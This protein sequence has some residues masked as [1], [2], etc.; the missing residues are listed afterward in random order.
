MYSDCPVVQ[1]GSFCIWIF[2]L[3]HSRRVVV[4]C[5]ISKVRTHF[6]N[7]SPANRSTESWHVTQCKQQQLS[8]QA[9]KKGK[10]NLATSLFSGIMAATRTDAS[11]QSRVFLSVTF[12][13]DK[14]CII[15][16][17]FY[18]H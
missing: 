9:T 6:Y 15:C 10:I 4:T 2:F 7:I 11:I 17:K 14:V 18:I 13:D 12:K 8:D 1:N 3:I 5:Q 16:V